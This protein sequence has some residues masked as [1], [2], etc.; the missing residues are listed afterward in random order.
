MGDVLTGIVAALIAQGLE[1]ER[2]AQVGVLVHARAGDEA[3]RGGERGLLPG[4]LI[5]CL[6]GVVN[7]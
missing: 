1:P 4:D 7:P 2:A 6:R 3:A 5:D